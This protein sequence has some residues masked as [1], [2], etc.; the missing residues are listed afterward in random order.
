MDR[1]ATSQRDSTARVV[2]FIGFSINA[3]LFHR[4]LYPKDTFAEVQR[5]GVSLC[6][7]TNETVKSYLSGVLSQVAEWVVNHQMRKLVLVVKAVGSTDPLEVWTFN[8][9][10][11]QVQ[12]RATDLGRDLLEMTKQIAASSAF[13]PERTEECTFEVFVFT[14]EDCTEPALWQETGL[15]RFPAGQTLPLRPFA[16]AVSAK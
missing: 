10:M 15:Q 6:I 1:P 13:L 7:T 11:T 3:I 2:E 12:G 5:H 16:T 9:Q 8:I 4:G 14:E